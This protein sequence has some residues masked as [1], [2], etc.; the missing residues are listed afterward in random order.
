M[1]RLTWGALALAATLVVAGCQ[2]SGTAASRPVETH[3][4]AM[5]KSY[6]FDPPVIQVPAGTTVTWRNDDHF[7]H[8]VRFLSGSTWRSAPLPPGAS[9]SFTF[10]QPGEYAYEC[11]FHPQQMKGRVIVVAR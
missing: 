3:Q 8:N 7:T 10:D 1:R 11:S 2:A 6:R 9:A 4:V 5:A